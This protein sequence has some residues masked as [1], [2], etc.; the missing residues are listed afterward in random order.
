MLSHGAILCNAMGACDLLYELED[1]LPEDET[2]LSFLP[3][4]HSYEHTAGQFFPLSIGAQIYYAESVEALAR[5]MAE[6][7][8]TIMTAVPRL[9]ETLHGRVVSGLH[10]KA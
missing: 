5:N 6:V 7:K 8:P 3:L 10:M 2:F 9:Y 4:S 1:R